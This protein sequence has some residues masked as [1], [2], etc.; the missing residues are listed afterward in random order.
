MCGMRSPRRCSPHRSG[1]SAPRTS[2]QAPRAPDPLSQ[3][4]ASSHASG[5]GEGEELWLFIVGAPMVVVCRRYYDAPRGR[6]S[7]LGSCEGRHRRRQGPPAWPPVRAAPPTRD[8]SCAGCG[9]GDDAGGGACGGASALPVPC[10]WTRCCWQ[11]SSHP[12]QRLPRAAREDILRPS[13]AHRRCASFVRPRLSSAGP[14]KWLLQPQTPG[15][16]AQRPSRVGRPGALCNAAR[17]LHMYSQR[18][19]APLVSTQAAGDQRIPGSLTGH[20]LARWTA[21]G[22]LRLR[23]MDSSLP[24]LL[25]FSR[26]HEWQRAAA[27]ETL[28]AGELRGGTSAGQRPPHAPIHRAPMEE[29]SFPPRAAAAPRRS[30][31]CAAQ[32]G[33]ARGGRSSQRSHLSPRFPSQRQLSVGGP[34]AL[35]RAQPRPGGARVSARRST[36]LVGDRSGRAPQGGGEGEVLPLDGTQRRLHH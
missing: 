6:C 30:N 21:A 22:R 18:C 25:S 28:P 5:C 27:A 36:P 29:G 10:C 8:W 9:T 26:R 23:G 1:R 32:R 2:A 13:V 19:P 20:T 16:G 12:C 14:R 11:L 3:S 31:E 24:A 4:A 7:P 15:L 34:T 35:R 17:L 33:W